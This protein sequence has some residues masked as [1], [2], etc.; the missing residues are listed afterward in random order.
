MNTLVDPLSNAKTICHICG[1]AHLHGPFDRE[2]Q[3]RINRE[4]RWQRIKHALGYLPVPAVFFGF[5]TLGAIFGPRSQPLTAEEQREQLRAKQRIEQID[6]QMEQL[7]NERDELDP[8]EP[9]DDSDR[10]GDV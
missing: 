8:P 3:L 1:K 9:P 4:H 5:M 7:Q 2:K 10:Y 6:Q